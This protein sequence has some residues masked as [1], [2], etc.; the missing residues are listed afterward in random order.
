MRRIGPLCRDTRAAEELK[1][2]M[3][4]PEIRAVVASL[5]DQRD[6]LLQAELVPKEFPTIEAPKDWTDP[7]HTFE[8]LVGGVE[9]SVAVRARNSEGDSE[10]SL[11]L[12]G[13]RTPCAVPEQCLPPVMLEAEIGGHQVLSTTDVQGLELEEHRS[14]WLVQVLG[15]HLHGGASCHR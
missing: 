14:T 4:D 3:R 15:G 11:A 10:W 8:G 9:F 2:A 6:A 13:L 7:R 12:R 1:A 5:S